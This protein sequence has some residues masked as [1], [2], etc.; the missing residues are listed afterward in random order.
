M[1][2]KP[3]PQKPFQITRTRMA[4]C[5]SLLALVLLAGYLLSRPLSPE[6]IRDRALQALQTKDAEALCRLADPEEL[7][8]THLTPD[9]VRRML[10][11]S[12]WRQ[13]KPQVLSVSLFADKPADKRSWIIQWHSDTPPQ[14][15]FGISVVDDPNIGWKLVLSDVVMSAYLYDGGKQ[16]GQKY[17]ERMRELDIVSGRQQDGE[18]TSYLPKSPNPNE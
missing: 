7:V 1:A 2:T 5:A 17:V 8:K 11:D 14:G 13:N 16:G 15:T 6:A 12:L 9:K 3:T 18:Y 4:L 10:Q